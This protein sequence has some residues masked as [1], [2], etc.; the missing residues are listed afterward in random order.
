MISVFIADDG[1]T[2]EQAELYFKELNA[3]AQQNCTSYRGYRVQDVADFSPVNDIIAQF[4]FD[5]ES[6]VTWFKL[7]WQ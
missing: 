4:G 2:Y 5:N 7:K 3:W 1:M 6:D